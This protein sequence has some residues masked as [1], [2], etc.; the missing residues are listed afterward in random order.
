MKISDKKRII[1][2][3]SDR[4][5]LC[6][7]D[8]SVL[9]SGTEERRNIRF[10]NL[11][12]IGI[13]QGDTVLDLGCGFGDFSQFLVEKGIVVKYFGYD[14]NPDLIHYARGKYPDRYFE[15]KDIIN[16]R[17][18]DFDYIVSTSCF[19]LPLVGQD[20]YAFLGELLEICYNHSK[21]GVAID[22]LSAYVD[23]KSKEGFHYSP[24]KIFKI[25]K[26]I[27]KRVQLRHDYPLFEFCIY[28]FPDFH[29]WSKE[30]KC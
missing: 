11:L 8:F 9:N 4:L 25:A 21:K 30:K 26:K 28:M 2:R 7:P 27:T 5:K 23:F 18:G 22:F 12:E 10:Q 29:G 3:Y 15:I 24:E 19:N 17:F 6:G 14:I 16:E 1:K 13:D 20:N